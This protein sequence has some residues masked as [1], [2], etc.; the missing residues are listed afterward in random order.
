MSSG[1][2]DDGRVEIGIALDGT[3]RLGQPAAVTAVA[4]AADQLGY[5]SVWCIGP[6]AATLVGAVAA[7][8]SRVR[9]GIETRDATPCASPAP[10]RVIGSWSS[11]RLPP[12]S[13]PSGSAA[14]SVRLDARAAAIADATAAR[15]A[16]TSGVAEV[17]IPL[18]TTRTDDGA[19]RLRRA[20]ELVEESP[21]RLPTGSRDRPE[22]SRGAARPRQA[23]RDAER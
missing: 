16:R 22:R 21:H 11:D 13:L 4:A 9:I 8:S 17:V 7:A 15:R 18:S 1:T 10:S 2:A 23:L 20:R 6:W 12:G 19:G 14:P 5:G 3:G